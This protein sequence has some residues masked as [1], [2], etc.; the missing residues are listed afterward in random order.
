[1]RE[2]MR[3]LREEGAVDSL[4]GRLISFEERFRLSGL[5]RILELESKYLPR[6]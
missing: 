2:V 1:M 4:D 6:G 3:T 5:D